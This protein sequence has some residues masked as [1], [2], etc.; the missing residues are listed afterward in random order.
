MLKWT[1]VDLEPKLCWLDLTK[2]IS[3]NDHGPQNPFPTPTPDTWQTRQLLLPGPTALWASLDF[4]YSPSWYNLLQNKLRVIMGQVV[5]PHGRCWFLAIDWVVTQDFFLLGQT[6][7][8]TFWNSLY[9]QR[10]EVNHEVPTGNKLHCEVGGK[11]WLHSWKSCDLG[12]VRWL[13]RNLGD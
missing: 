2:L 8:L 13:V 12:W 4:V 5:R 1:I 6:C 11:A 10:P 9:L 7:S 3:W